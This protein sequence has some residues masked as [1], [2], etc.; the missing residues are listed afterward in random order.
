[1]QLSVCQEEACDLSKGN[2]NPG[3]ASLKTTYE[4]EPESIGRPTRLRNVGVSCGES[5]ESAAAFLLVASI[6]LPLTR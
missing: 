6:P 5:V 3:E 2:P 4:T 1:M